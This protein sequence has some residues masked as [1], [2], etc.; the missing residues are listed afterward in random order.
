MAKI[1]LEAFYPYPIEH[2]WDALTEPES[3]AQ[4]LMENDFKPEVGAKFKFWAKPMMGW[5]GVA[6]CVLLEMEKPYK[7]S[8]SQCGND[9]GKDPFLITWTLRE[10]GAGTRLTLVHDGLK[11]VRGLLVKKVMGAGWKRMFDQKLPLIL[12][13]AAQKGWHD[14]PKERRLTK[15]D[16]HL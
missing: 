5:D 6:R 15:A 2:V 14:F 8:W 4:W 16:C 11:G 1:E 13:Y 9:E 10:E 3:L 12:E 7:L